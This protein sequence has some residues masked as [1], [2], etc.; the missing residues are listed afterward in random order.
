MKKRIQKNI[1]ME[2]K[3]LEFTKE[4]KDEIASNLEKLKQD[5]GYQLLKRKF[6]LE[7]ESID[8]EIALL[9]NKVSNTRS[10]ER[11]KIIVELER[12][13]QELIDLCGFVFEYEK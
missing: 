13:K 10:E 9:K 4:E 11:D 3:E 2:L 6:Y 8:Y 7:I 12:Q 1:D 5:K